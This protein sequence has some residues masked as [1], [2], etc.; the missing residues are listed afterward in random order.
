VTYLMNSVSPLGCSQFISWSLELYQVH[1]MF[2]SLQRC[3]YIL[4][5]FSLYRCL[6]IFFSLLVCTSVFYVSFIFNS[7]MTHRIMSYNLF[8]LIHFESL[9]STGFQVTFVVTR[10]KLNLNIVFI[11]SVIFVYVIHTRTVIAQSV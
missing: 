9:Y 6:P 1:F 4:L 3:S 2:S 10:M 5:P 11:F 7:N 8:P